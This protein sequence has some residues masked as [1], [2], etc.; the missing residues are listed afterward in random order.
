VHRGTHLVWRWETRHH[1]RVHVRVR[2]KYAKVTHESRCTTVTTTAT[3]ATVTTT[4][5]KA[6]AAT[7]S[8]PNISA[9]LDPSYTQDPSNPL[10]VTYSF[11]AAATY[12]DNGQTEPAPLPDGYLELFS[13]G[14]L[15]CSISVGA[16]VD[17]GQCLVT[18]SAYGDHTVVVDY[19]T[20]GTTPATETETEDIENPN[21]PAPTT[22]TSTTTTTTVAP[23]VPWV[24]DQPVTITGLTKPTP[25]VVA[26]VTYWA[27]LATFAPS[28]LGTD[29]PASF[30]SV[31]MTMPGAS[32][33]FC[34]YDL[35][36]L[37]EIY[38][39][40]S[41]GCG[42]SADPSGTWLTVSYSGYTLV[43]DAQGDSTVYLPA[44][45]TLLVP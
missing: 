7:V 42:F 33:P 30:G 35:P 41:G 6:P 20:N 17:G 21:P 37:L 27:V 36:S 29:D 19:V 3:G 45:A 23:Y 32:G 4:T 31:E 43:D 5:T 1:K 34:F 9:T 13:D 25:Y 8:A 40:D 18:Y 2:V 44:T 12:Q 16:S 38:D 14:S 28:T 26:G 15:A 11:S 24:T 10:A 39:G 22:T